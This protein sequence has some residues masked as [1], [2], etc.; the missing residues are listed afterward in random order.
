MTAKFA[1][2]SRRTA[3]T[4]LLPRWTDAP[5]AALRSTS[6][7]PRFAGRRHEARADAG[8]PSQRHRPHRQGIDRPV[9]PSRGD[10]VA[11]RAGEAE[12]GAGYLVVGAGGRGHYRGPGGEPATVARR[13]PAA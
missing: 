12:A 8:E 4:G 5:Q 1:S 9:E 2:E 13:D 7:F 6:R 11:D 10:R 3:K